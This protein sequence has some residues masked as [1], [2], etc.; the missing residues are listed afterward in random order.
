MYAEGLIS[1]RGGSTF[2]YAEGPAKR[3]PFHGCLWKYFTLNR[4][5]KRTRKVHL[6]SF[7]RK[8]HRT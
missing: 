8:E 3:A 6:R 2:P 5:G 1:V 4:E 7:Y